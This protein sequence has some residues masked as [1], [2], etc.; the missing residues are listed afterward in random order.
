[1]RKHRGNTEGEKAD[2]AAGFRIRPA[3]ELSWIAWAEN[4]PATDATAAL[5]DVEEALKLNPMSIPG[6]Q[7]KA[8]LWRKD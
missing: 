4:R 6:L 3:D 8:H 7:Q 5:A 2:R 1:M